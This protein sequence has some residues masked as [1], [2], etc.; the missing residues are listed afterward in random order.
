M[1]TIPENW[2]KDE[3]SNFLE[4]ADRNRH[5]SFA[6]ERTKF[7]VL[8]DI[9]ALFRKAIEISNNSEMYFPAL[10]LLLSHSS[11]LASVD[12][13]LS[14]QIT[15][16]YMTI[17]GCLENAL[18]GF[19][20]SKNPKSAKTWLER[21]ESERSLK[22]VKKEFKPSMM[23]TKLESYDK[24]VANIAQNIYCDSIN[25]GGHPNPRGLLTNLGL[26][27]EDSTVKFEVKYLNPKTVAWQACLKIVA[28]VGICSLLIFKLV[29]PERFTICNISAAIERVVKTEY[30]NIF[31][32]AQRSNSLNRKSYNNA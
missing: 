25:Y 18:Y 1:K 23:L 8:K 3:L 10:F 11:F 14:G 16:T 13:A 27:E 7:G 20:F 26:L 31:V 19:H 21:H 24:G 12:L 9:D 22:Q 6:N 5:A 32:E 2:G 28:E 4:S 29:F 30:S 15:P 17:R